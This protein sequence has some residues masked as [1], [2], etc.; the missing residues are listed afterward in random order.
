MCKRKNLYYLL[1]MLCLFRASGSAQASAPELWYWHHSYLATDQAV[2]S[3]ETLIDRAKAAGYTGVAFYDSSF[4][5]MSD[6]F[7]PS[8]NLTRMQQVMAYAA[9]KGMKVT[10]EAAPFGDSRD[11]LQADPNW[12]EASRVTGSQFQVNSSGTQLNFLNSF[13]GL[14]NAG[15]ES[16][17][18][19]WFSMGDAG[20]NVDYSVAHGGI[21]S[22]VITNAPA[23]ARFVQQVTLKPWRQYHLRLFYRSQNFSG[24]PAIYM[25]D[26]ANFNIMRLNVAYFNASG[27][28]GWTQLDYTFNSQSTTQG[29]LYFGIWGGSQGSLWFDDVLLEETALIYVTRRSGTPVQ[30]YDPNNTNHIYLEG[31]D[32][33]YI[34]DKQMTASRTPFTDNYHAPSSVTLPAG[35]HLQPGQIVAVDSY[36]AFPIPGQL[37]IAMCLTEPGVL[38]W[39][40]QNAQATQSVLP[41]G[42]GIFLQY[43]EL[44]QMNSCGSCR[45]KNMTPGQL[46]AAS[47]GQSIQVIN[48]VIPSAP[49]YVWSDMFDPYHNATGNY[50]YVEGDLSGAWS[51]VPS[52]V[53]IM[54]WNL[55]NLKN[56]LNWFS[57]LNSSQPTPHQ[58]IIAGYYDNGNGTQSAQQELTAAAGIP[59]IR[60]LMYTTWNDDYSQLENFAASAQANWS[61]YLS[62]IG[63][64]VSNP[65]VSVT[66]PATNPSPGT[67]TT[68]PV[69]IISKSSGKCL[70]ISG[71]SKSPGAVLLQWS[72]WGGPNQQWDLAANSDGTYQ[73]ISVNSGMSLDVAG[74]PSVTSDGANIVQ[75]PYWGGS[76]EKWQIQPTSDGYYQIVAQSSGKCLDVTG[77]PGATQDGALMEQWSCWGGDNQKFKLVP[78][79]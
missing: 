2:Q 23:N 63:G 61:T 70:D 29:S 20:T 7:W 73:V 34:S 6:S 17:K 27:S 51:G 3:S 44:R 43:D 9:A 24:S 60:G 32:Y 49:L 15:F 26:S 48:S 5:F 8:Q 72:C 53:T 14:A 67:L 50:Y 10:G 76:N 36:S 54:N 65:P 52:S 46:L 62:S 71:V 38:S 40:K 74:G 55:G 16:G 22:G 57:G 59:G 47:V 75:W 30:V 77:G 11:A 28:Q 56:S 39:M 21:A 66:P 42:A 1:S 33:N 4:S 19:G 45:A 12:A 41:S 64:A 18:N 58:Q 79:Q 13:P 69:Q 37:D 25:F 35:T 78:R 31:T 68:A